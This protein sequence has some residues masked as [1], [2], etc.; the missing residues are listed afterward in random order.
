MNRGRI[1]NEGKE[2]I[3]GLKKGTDKRESI[4]KETKIEKKQVKVVKRGNP[5]RNKGSFDSWW[6]RV[7]SAVRPYNHSVEALLRGCRPTA[8]DGEVLT[9]E[10]FYQFHKEKIEEGANRQLVEKVVKEIIGEEVRIMCLLGER[11]APVIKKEEQKEEEIEESDLVEMAKEI[12]G[13]Q[14]VE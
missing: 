9:L 13:G 4:E 8:Y 12:F 7:L 10:F 6:P 11:A 5:L 2:L 1:E 3:G 14:I